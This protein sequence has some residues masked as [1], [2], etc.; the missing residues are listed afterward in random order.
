MRYKAGF[1][2]GLAAGYVLGARAGRERYEQLARTARGFMDNP[3]VKQASG[4]VSQRGTELLNTATHKV[5]EQLGERVAPRLP[6]WAP[7]HRDPAAA[8]GDDWA[9]ASDVR[10]DGFSTQDPYWSGSS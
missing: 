2:T 8:R 6:S 3:R 4:T 9:E 10:K 1:V 5:G 7:G